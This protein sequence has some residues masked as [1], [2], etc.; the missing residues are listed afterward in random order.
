M[1]TIQALVAAVATVGCTSSKGTSDTDSGKSDFASK[2]FDCVVV[3]VLD[4][5]ILEEGLGSIYDYD[6]DG[7]P[8]ADEDSVTVSLGK[9]DLS[10]IES[11]MILSIGQLSIGLHDAKDVVKSVS[12]TG[13]I[14]WRGQQ[15]PE[16]PT[17]FNPEPAVPP[18]WRVRIFRPLGVGWVQ[19]EATDGTLT[20]V[21]K[22]DCR[23][24]V[25]RP[26]FDALE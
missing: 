8:G 5:N 18:M 9:S 25:A 17:E 15:A 6:S 20:D 12:E 21:A 22:I 13:V 26:D 7:F 11:K 24:G 1:R 19:T 3:E 10:V 4:S 16:E 2:E 23:K 14:S